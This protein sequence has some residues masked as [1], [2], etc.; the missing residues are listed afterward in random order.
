[1]KKM[2]VQLMLVVCI[3][4][5][6]TGCSLVTKGAGSWEI[7]AGIRTEKTSDEP[8][9]VGIESEVLEKSIEKIVDSMTDD[10]VS[11]DE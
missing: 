3:L 4:F 5:W 9:S 8:S 11:P 2:L 10:K 1:M 7:Y 6:T